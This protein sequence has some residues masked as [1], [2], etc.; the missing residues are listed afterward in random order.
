ASSWHGK[1]ANRACRAHTGD[2]VACKFCEP[3]CITRGGDSCGPTFGCW[4]GELGDLALCGNM[5][6]LVARVFRKPEPIGSCRN[7]FREFGCCRERELVHRTCGGQV[8]NVAC[9]AIGEPECSIGACYHSLGQVGWCYLKG[10]LCDCSWWGDTSYTISKF[11]KPNIAIG[12]LGDP[13][14]KSVGGWQRELG[15]RPCRGNATDTT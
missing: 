11:C 4:Y 12:P 3:K 6:Y 9:R 1:L 2:L 5:T 14:G 13:T 10:K 7:T 8:S 15:D